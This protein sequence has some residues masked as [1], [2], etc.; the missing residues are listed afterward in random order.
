MSDKP[1]SIHD[2]LSVKF[3]REVIGAESW[4]LD[5]LR[6]GVKLDFAALPP[7]SYTEPNNKSA[8]R[9]ME[10]L[11]E[12]V[13]EWEK[14]GFVSLTLAK[15]AFV[16]PMSVVVKDDYVAGTTKKRP[17]I[18]LSH[19]INKLLVT[20][21]FSMDTL[22]NCEPSV[23]PNDYQIIFDLENMYF[24]FW[25]HKEHRKFFSF[26]V[27]NIQGEKVYYTFNVMCYGYSLAAYI[28]TRVINPIK[29]FLHKLEIRLSMYIDDGR[30]LAQ[31]KLECKYKAQFVLNIFQLCSFNIQWKK[32]DLNPKQS[33]VFQG[34]ITDTIV[35]RYFIQQE[36]FSIT[37]ALI[38]EVLFKMKNPEKWFRVKELAVLLG[39]IHS[40]GRSHGNIVS[41]MTRHIQHVVGKEVFKAGWE[42]QVKLDEHC[43]RELEFLQEHL[44][45]FNGKLI[46]VTKE[47]AKT[48]GYQEISSFIQEVCNSDKILPG[49]IV[50]DA[51]DSHAFIFLKDKF[52]QVQ[53]FEFDEEKTLSSG[54]RELLAT[55]K[56]LEHCKKD[57]VNFKSSIV[58]W[59]RDS[60]NN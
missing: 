16:N 33:A 18:D 43:K 55:V 60:K 3:M 9:N 37:Q 38:E 5:I 28:V 58:Y 36:K 52:M 14:A 29:S 24:H 2:P 39:K 45:K 46:P 7:E 20:R 6:Y 50:S 40:L 41:V 48:V 21:P 27:L 49:L 47:G 19:C 51:S 42:S 22:S 1:Y 17:V 31:S 30:I 12:K 59:Q 35:M 25:L 11:T 32:T 54:H 26:S 57:N 34:F 15:P 56:F 53:E 44:S 10:F 23:L 13:T 8:Q 4:V